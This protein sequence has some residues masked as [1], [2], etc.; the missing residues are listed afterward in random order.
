MKVLKRR[1][2]KTLFYRMKKMRPHTRFLLNIITSDIWLSIFGAAD[3]VLFLYGKRFLGDGAVN[4]R[5]S[6]MATDLDCISSFI[7]V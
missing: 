2:E 3:F 5:N 4:H 1:K 6:N 7:K